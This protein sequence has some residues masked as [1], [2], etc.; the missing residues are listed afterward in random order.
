[1]TRFGRRM[2]AVLLLSMAAACTSPNSPIQSPTLTSFAEYRRDTVEHLRTQRRASASDLAAEVLLNAPREWRPS[3]SRQKGTPKKGILLVHGLG[4]SPWSFHDVGEQLAKR[5]FLVRTVLLSGHGT[6]PGDMLDI[7]LDQWRRLVREQTAVLQRDVSEVYL[8]GFSTGANL[9]TEYA[10]SNPD[11]AGLV[12]F[13]PAFKAKTRLGWT[14]ALLRRV[15]PWL[16]NPDGRMP[17][18]NAVRYFMVPTNGFAQF[19]QSSVAARQMLERRSYDKPVFMVAVQ[20]DSVLD[21]DYMLR[22]F[23]TRFPHPASRMIWYG[24]QPARLTDKARVAVRTDYLPQERISQFSHMGI[25]FHPRNQLYGRQG[26]I[27]I[28]WNGQT[29]QAMKVCETGG[30]V[31]FSDWGHREDGKI[32]ARLTYNPYFDWQTSVMLSVLG[33]TVPDNVVSPRFTQES[34]Q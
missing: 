1:M 9:V 13:S 16:I 3:M 6:H 5:G 8:G 34:R 15:R 22:T 27:R 7:E 24:K 28:C 25:L 12:L 17:L 14:A 30:Q 2:A 18:Q 20:N 11:I 19:H 4:D 32:H 23:Q 26:S 29:E 33:E 21:A 10:Y 31:W